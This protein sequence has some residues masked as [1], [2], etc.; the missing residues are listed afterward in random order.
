MASSDSW[1]ARL[2]LQKANEEQ[3]RH[4]RETKQPEDYERAKQTRK[5]L[6]LF[7]IIRNLSQLGR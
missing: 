5:A 4:A 2:L 3:W 6:S 1:I 7:D